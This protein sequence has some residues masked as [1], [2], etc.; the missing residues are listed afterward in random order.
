MFISKKS[1]SYCSK[2]QIK[3]DT[4]KVDWNEI[5]QQLIIGVV[6]IGFTIPSYLFLKGRIVKPSLE[7]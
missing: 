2:N 4:L 7:T 3:N 1:P 6:V 5:Q